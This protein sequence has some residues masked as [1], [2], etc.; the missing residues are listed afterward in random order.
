MYRFNPFIFLL[1]TQ[2]LSNQEKPYDE[3]SESASRNEGMEK[4]LTCSLLFFFTVSNT[5]EKKERKKKTS[6]R[7]IIRATNLSLIA[8]AFYIYSNLR[9]RRY[10]MY[11][12]C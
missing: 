10:Q 5:I 8:D 12:T 9:C 11:Y 1:D 4:C 2:I 6:M 7:V 3:N